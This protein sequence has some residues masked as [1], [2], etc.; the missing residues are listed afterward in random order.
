[1]VQPNLSWVKH[2]NGVIY[3]A[4]FGDG[5]YIIADFTIESHSFLVWT[6][7]DTKNDFASAKFGNLEL[8]MNFAE[9]HSKNG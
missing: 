5:L 7:Y 8:A 4:K 1:M 2:A 9:E 6:P 3:D